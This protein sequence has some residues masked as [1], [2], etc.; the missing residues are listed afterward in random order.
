MK[1]PACD[2]RCWVDSQHKGPS[3]CPVC[4]GKGHV[5]ETSTLKK[6]TP[7]KYNQDAIW[8]ELVKD[9]GSTFDEVLDRALSVLESKEVKECTISYPFIVHLLFDKNV[10][11]QGNLIFDQ[12]RLGQLSTGQ[13]NRKLDADRLKARGYSVLPTGDVQAV[14]DVPVGPLYNTLMVWGRDMHDQW[15]M[16]DPIVVDVN[17]KGNPFFM[18]NNMVAFQVKY[19]TLKGIRTS[20][21]AL[22]AWCEQGI[23]HLAPVGKIVNLS[24]FFLRSGI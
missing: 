11:P 4:N 5:A 13:A 20:L 24:L 21:M 19:K 22:K 8:T 10:T 17:R 2:G 23:D 18:D 12:V 6:D 14:N 15:G 16:A 1:C 7:G 9:T 3:I